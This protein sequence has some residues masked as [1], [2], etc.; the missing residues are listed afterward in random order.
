MNNNNKYEQYEWVRCPNCGHKLFRKKK[1][2]K[3]IEIEIKC[4]SCKKILE[5]KI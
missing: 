3:Q 1:S 2:S 4:S 5:V